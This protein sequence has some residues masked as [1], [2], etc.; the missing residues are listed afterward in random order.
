MSRRDK[1]IITIGVVCGIAPFV[2]LG[3]FAVWAIRDLNSMEARR[4]VL[5]YQT[6]HR[7][8]LEACR[9]LSRQVAGGELRH[10]EY[11]V[12]GH[13]PDPET[14]QFPQLILDL[15]PLR[16]EIESNG[17]VN[18]MM[19]PVVLYGVYALPENHEDPPAYPWR[20]ELIDGLWYYDEGFRH[21]PE[22]QKDVEELLKKKAGDS[23]GAP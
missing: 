12:H 15:D 4:P 14:R 2:Y 10:G 7:A 17:V 23:S 9:E 3:Y 18:L 13:H 8:L 21:H 22:R 11:R 19:S 1:W 6:D 16:A 5:L 20:T